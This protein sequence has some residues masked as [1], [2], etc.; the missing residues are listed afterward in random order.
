MDVYSPVVILIVGLGVMAG[1]G[2]ETGLLTIVTVGKETPLVTTVNVGL[3]EPDN[4]IPEPIF[5]DTKK[6]KRTKN[7]IMECTFFLYTKH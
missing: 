6:K 4:P 5:P 1:L 2:V 7:T 3:L